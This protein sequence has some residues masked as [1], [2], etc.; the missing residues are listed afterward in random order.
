MMKW[1]PVD[2]CFGQY[3]RRLPLK[4]FLKLAALKLI[5]EQEN[6]HSPWIFIERKAHKN[7]AYLATHV[8]FNYWFPNCLLVLFSLY[9]MHE[10]YFFVANVLVIGTNEWELSTTKCRSTMNVPF[11]FVADTVRIWP[12]YPR[13]RPRR[14]RG[15]K[16]WSGWRRMSTRWPR[17]CWRP[18]WPW[19]GVGRSSA[20][21]TPS[22]RR[23]GS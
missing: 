8:A 5:F 10:S 21:R 14:S 7:P 11:H 20:G 23:T 12:G 3:I 4:S 6:K 9:F 15:Q 17:S 19:T 1:Y 16:F 22:R 18:R 2:C 13:L